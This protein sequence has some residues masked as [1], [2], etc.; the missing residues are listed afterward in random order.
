MALGQDDDYV[1][2]TAFDELNPDI[3]DFVSAPYDI[4]IGSDGNQISQSDWRALNVNQKLDCIYRTVAVN[5]ARKVLG[6]SSLKQIRYEKNTVN[7]TFS[8]E[9]NG[10]LVYSVSSW[11]GSAPSSTAAPKLQLT[12]GKR[13][14]ITFPASKPLNVSLFPDGRGDKDGIPAEPY[15]K[16]VTIDE[17]AKTLTIDVAND[18][19]TLED[20]KLYYYCETEAG[21]GN[22]LEI[23]IPYTAFVPADTEVEGQIV[24]DENTEF[25][26]NTPVYDASQFVDILVADIAV[27]S[28]GFSSHQTKV[29][30][31]LSFIPTAPWSD[32]LTNFKKKCGQGRMFVDSEDAIDAYGNK[33]EESHSTYR[34]STCRF[35]WGGITSH[36]P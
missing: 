7:E 17:N 35:F 4:L 28:S 9:N 32:N 19:I 15:T 34:T 27:D 25:Q 12:A 18:I 6:Y 14:V 36:R 8:T 33:I 11:G 21:M 13:Y 10:S 29:A 20:Q 3:A 23:D 1:F 26:A 31:A 30:N 22:E 5:K 16:G 2:W 24:P